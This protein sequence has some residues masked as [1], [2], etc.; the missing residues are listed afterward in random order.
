MCPNGIAPAKNPQQA[1]LHFNI[2]AIKLLQLAQDGHYMYKKSLR[3][4][5]EGQRM[6][7]AL[8][9]EQLPGGEWTFDD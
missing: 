8:L 1:L 6:A 7:Q 5:I 4:A 2:A 9:M 3:D